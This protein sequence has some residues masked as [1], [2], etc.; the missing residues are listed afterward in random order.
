MYMHKNICL[1][2]FFLQTITC[3]Q[4]KSIKSGLI[5]Q[6]DIPTDIK[7]LE[8]KKKGDRFFS[9]SLRQRTGIFQIF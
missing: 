4:S 1:T 2:L 6:P 9:E 8:P 3:C 7:N 5:T